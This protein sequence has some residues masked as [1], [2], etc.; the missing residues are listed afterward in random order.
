MSPKQRRRKKNPA[1]KKASGGRKREK[2]RKNAVTVLPDD[3]S[4]ETERVYIVYPS[5]YYEHF[6]PKNV[7]FA[8]LQKYESKKKKKKKSKKKGKNRK[9]EKDEGE[10][11]YRSLLRFS[12]YI[13]NATP[14][15]SSSEEARQEEQ[16]TAV[17][18][19]VLLSTSYLPSTPGI[20][21]PRLYKQ[22]F[23]PTLK[24]KEMD[25]ENADGGVTARSTPVPYYDRPY[26]TG[27]ATTISETVMPPAP[28]TPMPVQVDTTVTVGADA[29]AKEL[30]E[31]KFVMSGDKGKGGGNGFVKHVPTRK[32]GQMGDRV[33]TM[34]LQ[35]EF[36]Q[37][38][39]DAKKK[40]G[41]KGDIQSPNILFGGWSRPGDDSESAGS[42]QYKVEIE[43][44]DLSSE[45]EEESD[46][47]GSSYD[48]MEEETTS[49]EIVQ[50]IKY[51]LLLRTTP[52]PSPPSDAF[53]GIVQR[54]GYK[55]YASD[56]FATTTPK[57]PTTEGG[58]GDKFTY[59]LINPG[60]PYPPP[61]QNGPVPGYERD[62]YRNNIA[63]FTQPTPPTNAHSAHHYTA[64]TKAR[65]AA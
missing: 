4:G 38:L 58:A 55:L 29:T 65:Y 56:P 44:V 57:P 19:G 28:T 62:W 13:D 12:G 45:G 35:K 16:E 18:P 2:E 53:D 23:K 31:S 11:D 41:K 24:P 33:D 43:K 15:Q 1:A 63:Y 61:Y 30:A 14:D 3:G 46:Y 8:Q 47:G 36:G 59:R 7:T 52:P 42:G 20:T 6:D 54:I 37:T 27:F 25:R 22:R 32:A 10:H 50:K 34:W 49:A 64:K 40:G 51:S 26:S 17:T 39:L 48:G 9:K 5:H 21:V 60:G